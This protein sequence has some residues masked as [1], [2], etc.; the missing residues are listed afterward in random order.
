MIEGGKKGRD[1]EELERD[2]ISIGIIITVQS[3]VCVGRVE[4]TVAHDNSPILCTLPLKFA[5]KTTED[6][7]TKH[8]PTISSHFLSRGMPVSATCQR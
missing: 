3:S 4:W 2:E 5:S 6:W 1:G 8:R 7:S